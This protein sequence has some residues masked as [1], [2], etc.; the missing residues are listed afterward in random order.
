MSRSFAGLRIR[1][2]RRALGLSQAGLAKAAG[3]SPS[4]LN[5][6]EHN[7]RPVAGRVMT[8]LARAL[9]VPPSALGEEAALGVVA[10][11]REAAADWPVHA[12]EVDVVEEFVGRY[13]GWARMLATLDQTVRAQRTS[14]EALSDR[15]THDPVLQADLHEMLTSITAIRS[16][17]SILASVEDIEAGQRQRFVGAIHGESQRL[18]EVAGALTDYFDRAIERDAPPATPEE[19]VAQALEQARY[20][21]PT[22]ENGEETLDDVVRRLPVRSDAAQ[23]ELRGWLTRWQADAAALPRTALVPPLDLTALAAGAGTDVPKV[24]R[25]LAFLA[26]PDLPQMGLVVVNGAGQMVL[27]RPRPDWPFSRQLPACA[28]WPVFTALRDPGLTHTDIVVNP[29]GARFLAISHAEL[30]RPATTGAR[31][32]VEATMLIVPEAQAGTFV[33]G[34]GRELRVGPSCRICARRACAERIAPPVLDIDA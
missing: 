4:Y 33:T 8:A 26:A 28:L 17:A 30:H 16:T 19:E 7:R 29:D 9:D 27:R 18:S 13:P 6:I 5:L 15:L 1:E 20:D 34:P 23:A 2:R 25:R 11:L 21:M 12:P 32:R 31:P 22:L 10:A 24:M 3:I 14:I